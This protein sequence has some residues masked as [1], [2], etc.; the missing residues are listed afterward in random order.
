MGGAACTCLPAG[1]TVWPPLAAVDEDSYRWEGVVYFY[2]S[3]HDPTAYATVAAATERM[4]RDPSYTCRK[5]CSTEAD[6]F[7]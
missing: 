7:T 6:R 4:W 1:P 3:W 2:I 5:P